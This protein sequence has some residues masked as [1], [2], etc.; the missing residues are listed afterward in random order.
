M[1]LALLVV[2]HSNSPS[3]H[4]FGRETLYRAVRTLLDTRLVVKRYIELSDPPRHPFGRETLYKDCQDPPGHPFGRETLCTGL[5]TPMSPCQDMYVPTIPLLRYP[6]THHAPYS[7]HTLSEH[8]HRR[9]KTARMATFDTNTLFYDPPLGNT[10][11][12]SLKMT[13]RSKLINRRP[14]LGRRMS[15]DSFLH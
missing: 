7:V 14:E 1:T 13:K 10:V 8:A 15:G 2:K 5:Q 9:Q 11:T 6:L 3:G 12:L 4:P